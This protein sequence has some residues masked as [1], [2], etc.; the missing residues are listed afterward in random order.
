MPSYSLPWFT[1]RSPVQSQGK[2]E[3][4]VCAHM[5]TRTRVG[6]PTHTGEGNPKSKNFYIF[7]T[8]SSVVFPCAPFSPV[9]SQL[10]LYET[11]LVTVL[12]HKFH[13]LL[14][15]FL[16]CTWFLVCDRNVQAEKPCCFHLTG[17]AKAFCTLWKV[18]S[19]RVHTY[20]L[21]TLLI[22]TILEGQTARR[23]QKAQ[24]FLLT[25]PSCEEA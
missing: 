22:S 11:L 23:F 8:P 24:F 14:I 21:D 10:T 20:V 15:V 18:I 1:G 12:S 19:C 5:H 9:N 17:L 16:S 6:T 25:D 2:F 3:V 4:H 13:K 7:Q